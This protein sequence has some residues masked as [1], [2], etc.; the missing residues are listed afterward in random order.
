M[1]EVSDGGVLM[2]F[3]KWRAL[4][5]AGL[6]RLLVEGVWVGEIEELGIFEIGGTREECLE[7]A[8]ATLTFL[9]QEYAEEKDE[10]MDAGAQALARRLRALRKVSFAR[11]SR[12]AWARW[13]KVAHHLMHQELT[14]CIRCRWVM[15][16]DVFQRVGRRSEGLECVACGVRVEIITPAVGPEPKGH[17]VWR[18]GAGWIQSDG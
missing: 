15:A 3:R 8:L 14:P 16:P 13:S 12:A 5:P 1:V 7:K 10:N 9:T 6:K 18:A 4:L 17:G 11:R 2:R